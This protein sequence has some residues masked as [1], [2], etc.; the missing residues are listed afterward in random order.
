MPAIRY[1]SIESLPLLG[2]S[3]A[4]LRPLAY[5]LLTQASGSDKGLSSPGAGLEGERESRRRGATTLA[6][7]EVSAAFP[8]PPSLSLSLSLSLYAHTTWLRTE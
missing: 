7:M 6:A 1:R 5:P 8:S 4:L 3:R 2:P